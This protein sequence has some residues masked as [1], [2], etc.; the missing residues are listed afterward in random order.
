MGRP[1]KSAGSRKLA[2]TVQQRSER[3][4]AHACMAADLPTPGGPQIRTGTRARVAASSNGVRLMAKL[5]LRFHYICLIAVCTTRK[6]GESEAR[7]R[8]QARFLRASVP[9]GREEVIGAVTND[10]RFSRI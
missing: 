9:I 10:R 7:R 8:K 4:F 5:L 2:I 1:P 3:P 6:G